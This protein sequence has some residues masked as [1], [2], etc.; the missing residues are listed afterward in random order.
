MNRYRLFA[1]LFAMSHLL[2][3]V[4]LVGGTIFV[5]YNP[6]Y[7]YW[8]LTIVSG[9]LL[10]NLFLGYCPLTLWEERVRRKL[11]QRFDHEGSFV[12]TYINK[13]FK[14]KISE[15]TMTKILFCVK[16]GIYVATITSYVMEKP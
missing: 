14:I 5:F 13:I 3:I 11:D 10:L 6:W 9:T 1:N 4:L 16:L 12:A 15:R 2:W 7:F 8:H